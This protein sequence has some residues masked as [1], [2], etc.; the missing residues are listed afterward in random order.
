MSSSSSGGGGVKTIDQHGSGCLQ[1]RMAAAARRAAAAARALNASRIGTSTF[2]PHPS[3]R[4]PGSTQYRYQ[5]VARPP[6]R[7]ACCWRSA[8]WP[9][10]YWPLTGD[11]DWTGLD[12]T[13]MRRDEKEEKEKSR[14]M[15]G[16]GTTVRETLQR[17]TFRTFNAIQGRVEATPLALSI[18]SHLILCMFYKDISVQKH[19]SSCPCPRLFPVRK[20]DIF[21]HTGSADRVV[22][23][24]AEPCNTF[25]RRHSS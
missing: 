11:K 17:Q 10:P 9:W 14:M 8:A 24:T 5:K 22:N 6:P 13:E 20:V 25:K 2:R 15:G 21:H 19:I 7:A 1:M 18:T 4:S 16:E 12:W 3:R 23:I